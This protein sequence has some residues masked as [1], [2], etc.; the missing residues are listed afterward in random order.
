MYVQV[1]YLLEKHIGIRTASIMCNIIL[2][3]FVFL[4]FLPNLKAVTRGRLFVEN[5]NLMKKSEINW[6]SR[7]QHIW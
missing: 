7:L 5:A 2:N 1:V 3:L 4:I 6:K